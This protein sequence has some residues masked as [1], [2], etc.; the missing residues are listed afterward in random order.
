MLKKI[1]MIINGA[2]SRESFFLIIASF[3]PTTDWRYKLIEKAYNDAKDAFR[4]R[5]RDSGDERYFEHIRAVTLIL[6]LYLR[7]TNYKL[8]VAALLHDIVED[9]PSWTIA[10]VTKEYGEE[11]AAYVDSL[12][13]PSHLFKDKEKCNEVYHRRFENARRA[14]FLIKLADRLHNL[15]TL[16]A[17]SKEKRLRKV[18]E[19]EI[20]YLPYA[21]K[22]FILYHEILAAIESLK[23]EKKSTKKKTV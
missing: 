4:G 15:L 20:H 3:F 9:I 12:T 8:I 6:I 10:R 17:C 13:K 14:F 2:R 1:L 11:I 18:I 16:W 22:H 5:F 7:V 23:Q 21:E 19:T